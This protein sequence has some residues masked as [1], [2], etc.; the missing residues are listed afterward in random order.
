MNPSFILLILSI[1]IYIC[2][3][4]ILGTF[5]RILYS[6]ILHSYSLLLKVHDHAQDP[7]AGFSE[8][9]KPSVEEYFSSVPG[10]MLTLFMSITGGVS[11]EDVI[12]PLLSMSVVWVLFFLFYATWPSFGRWNPFDFGVAE[13][14]CKKH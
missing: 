11:W 9:M 10:T 4:I 7:M 3:H 8:A 14:S 13:W 12:H 2:R 1:Y 6:L 5:H